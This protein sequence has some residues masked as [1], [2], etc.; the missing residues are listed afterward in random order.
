MRTL[1]LYVIAC[2]IE[3]DQIIKPT[4]F[5]SNRLFNIHFSYLPEFKGMYTSAIPIL[6]G[7]THT[8]VTLHGID[9]GIDTGPIIAQ[10]KFEIIL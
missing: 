6:Q 2:Y 3:F 10:E 4:E 7:S 1:R 5:R 8:G 9:Q